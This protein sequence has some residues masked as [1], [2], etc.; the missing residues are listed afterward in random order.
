LILLGCNAGMVAAMYRVG[1]LAFP[2]GES[3]MFASFPDRAV[4][5]E[6]MDTISIAN[7]TQESVRH[8]LYAHFSMRQ[9]VLEYLDLCFEFA[10]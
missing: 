2:L 7:E 9:D 1:A 5:N 6:I 10:V 8:M 3:I 4:M